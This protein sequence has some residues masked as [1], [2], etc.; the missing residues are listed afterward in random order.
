MNQL[1][2]NQKSVK[3]IAVIRALKL[4]D[5]LC[6]IPA[7]RLL[8][9]TMPYSRIYLIGLPWARS[10]SR[11]YRQYFDGFIR[12]PGYPGMPEQQLYN[13]DEVTG[14]FKKIKYHYYDLVIQMHGNGSVTNKILPLLQSRFYLGY[15]ENGSTHLNNGT[16]FAYPKMKNEININLELITSGFGLTGKRPNKELEFPVLPSDYSDIRSVK[17]SKMLKT[18]SYVVIHPGSISA[19]PWKARYFSTVGNIVSNFGLKVVITGSIQEKKVAGEVAQLMR[20]K[21]Y[22]LAGKTTLGALALII[23]NARLVIS[24]DTGISHLAAAVKTRSIVI[25]TTSDPVRW[26]PL[27]RELH[28]IIPPSLSAEPMNVFNA[29]HRVWHA[30]EQFKKK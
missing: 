26:A 20:E 2:K 24:N 19:R 21:A 23:K 16:F 18:H 10:F 7:I 22:N 12:F 4:G 30:E 29:V 25:F 14:F 28:H 11:R 3:R 15:S 6:S 1:T 8:K 17:E 9:E 13:P 5:M 27:D